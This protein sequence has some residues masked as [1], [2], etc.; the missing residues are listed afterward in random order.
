MNFNEIRYKNMMDKIFQDAGNLENLI[1]YESKVLVYEDCVVTLTLD[2]EGY[3]NVQ[4]FAGDVKNV[5][6]ETS[7]ELE[8]LLGEDPVEEIKSYILEINKWLY[9]GGNNQWIRKKF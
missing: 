8:S 3:A 7:D 2:E 6:I 9:L 5:Y 4:I 1:P